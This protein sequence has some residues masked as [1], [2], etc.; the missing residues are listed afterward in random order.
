MPTA[1]NDG[2]GR[3]VV[4]PLL[5]HAVCYEGEINGPGKLSTTLV[6][7]AVGKAPGHQLTFSH[8][9]PPI[10][11][12]FANGGGVRNVVIPLSGLTA[13]CDGEGKR[14]RERNNGVSARRSWKSPRDAE[15]L[16]L[17]MSA[18][19]VARPH[20]PH[21]RPPRSAATTSAV[22]THSIPGHG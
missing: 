19:A 7:G 17:L 20:T 21:R 9:R 14:T 11:I 8:V 2:G 15:G 12:T 13:G 1:V 5:G 4:S 16:A 22:A 18:A 3:G 6:R 10:T